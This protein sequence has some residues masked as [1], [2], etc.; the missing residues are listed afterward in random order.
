MLLVTK[1]TTATT[2][3]RL[4]LVCLLVQD[5]ARWLVYFSRY[6]LKQPLTGNNLQPDHIQLVTAAGGKWGQISQHHLM[7][8]S[9]GCKNANGMQCLQMWVSEV[10]TR[11]TNATTFLTVQGSRGVGGKRKEAVF[12]V[13][14]WLCIAFHF[15]TMQQG[16]AWVKIQSQIHL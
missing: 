6:L 2:T 4:V 11:K 13:R 8:R 5:A 9:S 10:G 14:H 3:K 7:K 15:D 12:T 16:S 1:N